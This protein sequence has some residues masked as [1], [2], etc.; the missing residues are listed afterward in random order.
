MLVVVVVVVEMVVVVVVVAVVIIMIL[1][2]MILTTAAREGIANATQ[3]QGSGSEWAT[4]PSTYPYPDRCHS[5][6][7]RPLWRAPAS[8]SWTQLCYII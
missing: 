4:D 6:L 7:S 1:I 8:R 5:S 2:I 3:L